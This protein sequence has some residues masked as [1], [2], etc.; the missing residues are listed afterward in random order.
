MSKAAKRERQRLNREARRQ[1]ELA[2]VK[3][4]KRLKAVRNVALLLLPL[5]VLFVVLQVV[6]DDDS[7]DGTDSTAEPS[8]ATVSTTMGDIVIELDPEEA[9]ETV[10]NFEK[11]AEEGFYDG[12]SVHRASSSVGVIQTGDPN[13]DGSGGPGYT[14]EDELP[15][16]GPYQI[17]DVAMANTGEPNS[18]GSQFFIITG[19]A[20]TQLPQT[21]SR[22]GRVVSGLEIAQ[23]I[24]GLAP[25]EGDGP[26]TQP[27]QLVGVT[28]SDTNPVASTTTT[29]APDA[30]ATTAPATPSS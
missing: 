30:T 13:G 4:R 16:K 21:Y 19:E 7:G 17:G 3:R 18:A 15:T 26:P 2:W 8:F 12:L 25:P 27:V 5:V 22:F 1:A 6:R 23:L 11:L 20:G 14:I 29:V 24:Q 9:P 28:I 10:A